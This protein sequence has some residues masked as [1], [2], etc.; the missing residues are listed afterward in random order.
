MKIDVTLTT[1]YSA[2]DGAYLLILAVV[3]IFLDSRVTVE[4]AMWIQYR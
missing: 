4:Q 2:R 1:R 3:I